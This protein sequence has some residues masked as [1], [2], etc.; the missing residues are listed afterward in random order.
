MDDDGVGSEQAQRLR[1]LLKAAGIEV[2][3]LWLHSFR[4]G[5]E[6]GE[7]EIDAYL[8]HALG[9]PRLERDLLACAANELID[10]GADGHAPYSWELLE[11]DRK[12]TA[13]G[14]GGA[15]GDGGPGGT[16]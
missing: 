11:D 7:V 8:H 9:M 13:D 12:E 16:A 2:G 3:T 15:D 5:G 10:H 1:R 14:E 4:L 6:V